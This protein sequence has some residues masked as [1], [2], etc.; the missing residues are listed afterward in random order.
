[1][2]LGG[3]VAEQRDRFRSMRRTVKGRILTLAHT[4]R[5]KLLDWKSWIS[6][7]CKRHGSQ[8]EGGRGSCRAGLTTTFTAQRELRPPKNRNS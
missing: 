6:T 4:D 3:K 2:V 7:D 1:M 5:A 8:T